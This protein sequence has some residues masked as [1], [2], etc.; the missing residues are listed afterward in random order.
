MHTIQRTA[1]HSTQRAAYDERR[2][3]H[4]VCLVAGGREYDI[5][6]IT[7]TWSQLRGYSLFCVP[8]AVLPEV[9]HGTHTGPHRYSQKLFF[10][11]CVSAACRIVCA[12]APNGT[13]KVNSLYP[14]LCCPARCCFAPAHCVARA[15]ARSPPACAQL[16]CMCV[17]KAVCALPQS[18]PPHQLPRLLA[19]GSIACPKRSELA[20]L[21]R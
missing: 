1:L 16:R 6:S 15:R 8:P 19:S 12:H 5:S 11:I 2:R 3:E 9:R 10:P 21:A 18:C 14:R 13:L 20:A 17:L 4:G 7:A